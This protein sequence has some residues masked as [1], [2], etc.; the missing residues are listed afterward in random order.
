[1]TRHPKEELFNLRAARDAAVTAA[2]EA[3]RDSTRLTRLLTIL[4]D[5]GTGSKVLDKAL[6]TLSEL[7]LADIVVLIDPAGTGSFVPLAAIGLPEELQDEPFSQSDESISMRVLQTGEPQLVEDA[8][9]YSR[10]DAQLKE[11]AVHTVVGLPVNGGDFTR[12][13]LILGRLSKRHFTGDEVALLNTM[14]YRI[15]RTLIDA[16]RNTQFE[17]LVKSGRQLSCRLDLAH[18]VAEAVEMLPEIVSGDS[19]AIVLRDTE[20]QWYCAAHHNMDES[21]VADMCPL[22]ERLI[23]NTPLANGEAYT[24]ADLKTIPHS[25]VLSDNSGLA[26]NACA[27]MAIP[28]YR[29]DTLHGV[30]FCMRSVS[31]AF[32]IGTLQ[33]GMLFGD[34]VTSAIDN[35]TLYQTVHNELKE[36]KRLEEV[37]RKWERQ[38]QLLQK[39][40]SLNSMA[41]AI[42][43]H[44]NNQ[45]CV[46]FGN[47]EILSD[48]LSG[49]RDYA[50][51]LSDAMQA[52]QKASEVSRS[53]L[54]YIGQTVGVRKPLDLAKICRQSL[55]LL[56]AA[57]PQRVFVNVNFSVSDLRIHG[58]S[59]LIQ[60]VL[61]NLVTNAYE[62]IGE[63]PGTIGIK[64]ISVRGEDIPVA[65][66]YPLDWKA[67][68]GD[69]ACLQVTDNGC[70]VAVEDFDKLFDPFFSRKRV[71]R[72][73]GLSVALGIVKAHG[74]GITME[75]TSGRGSA[76]CVYLPILKDDSVAE[77]QHR[78]S[79]IPDGGGR[80][81][82]LVDDE[83]A[84]RDVTGTIIAR[85][86][87]KVFTAADGLEAL[88]LFKQ[89][90]DNIA[91]V[92]SDLSMPGMNGWETMTAIHEVS[93]DLPIVLM[94]GHD[95]SRVVRESS[96]DGWETL[97]L[98]KPFQNAE[99]WDIIGKALS[100][101]S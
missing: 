39:A 97:F 8:A 51:P 24:T 77:A 92:L 7:F 14:A 5:S 56:Q 20:N 48:E 43:H 17:K 65:N 2:R 11:M 40:N 57:T 13:V 88:R 67:A 3:V 6:S 76:F 96:A 19:A 61:T 85:R 64:L 59:S 73:L 1:M 74:G 80:G 37:Q 23:G 18:V 79:G 33:T 26:K 95:E 32:H 84:I 34:Q 91:I 98:R 25:E 70:G 49:N 45:L 53:M 50:I 68:E 83:K 63:N 54:T 47:L 86:G 22:A 10:L 101:R 72:G 87:F 78:P 44:F 28:I 38:Q 36:R 27:L 4:N 99:L 15:G 42:A 29:D 55:P 71:G 75:S 81:L 30:L 52:A 69:F 93:P 66:R 82:L 12:G 31:I 94:S 58:N 89:N 60:Q 90:K 100:Q 21:S 46:V 9:N 62:A 16:Q 41:G 35:A